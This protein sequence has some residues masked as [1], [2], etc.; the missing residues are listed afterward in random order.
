[1]PN[2][3]GHQDLTA[4]DMRSLLHE[5]HQICTETVQYC[6][7]Q[8]GKHAEA[9]HI[10]LLLDC[11]ELCQ[12]GEDLL[13]RGSEQFS[14]YSAALADVC[15]RCAQDCKRFGDDNQMRACAEVCQRCADACRT[16]MRRAA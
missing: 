1:M 11:A 2:M 13:G 4:V 10:R 16:Q 3:P 12:T 9:T 7:E 8:G 15:E 14:T 6:R 5:C